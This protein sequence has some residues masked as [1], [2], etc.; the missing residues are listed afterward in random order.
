MKI[1]LLQ[2]RYTQACCR[3]VASGFKFVTGSYKL[4]T[5][6]VTRGFK[7]VTDLLQACCEPFTDMYKP[8]THGYHFVTHAYQRWQWRRQDFI[9]GGI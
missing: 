7:F 1:Q 8:V 3:L 9:L 6:F 4:A 5:D 2:T